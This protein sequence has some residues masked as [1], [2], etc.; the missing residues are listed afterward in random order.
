VKALHTGHGL[1]KK[2]QGE[3]LRDFNS[4]NIDVIVSCKAISRANDNPMIGVILNLLPWSIDTGTF[5]KIQISVGVWKTRVE[6]I[7]AELF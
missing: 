5:F 2:T 4:F 6:K 3:I 7:R 1:S